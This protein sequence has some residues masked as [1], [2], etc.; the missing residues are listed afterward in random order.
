MFLRVISSFHTLRTVKSSHRGDNC[1]SALY[2]S[3]T[4]KY[5]VVHNEQ[6]PNKMFS[7]RS[8]RGPA[9]DRIFVF[10]PRLRVGR[11]AISYQQLCH[12]PTHRFLLVFACVRSLLNLETMQL[13]N[14]KIRWPKS[15]HILVR[16]LTSCA[17]GFS[18]RKKSG[19]IMH[20]RT[21]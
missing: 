11:E 13:P 1:F 6:K 3:R 7:E 10:I 14:L 19:P 17:I 12:H 20:I 21:A 9:E 5:L 4:G 15:Y 18:N 16:N 8:G 2:F